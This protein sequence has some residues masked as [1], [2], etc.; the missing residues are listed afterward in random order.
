MSERIDPVVRSARSEMA[1]SADDQLSLLVGR[2]A[3]QDVLLEFGLRHLWLMLVT[4][5]NAA[6]LVPD[7]LTPLVIARAPLTASTRDPTGLESA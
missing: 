4:P 6:H 5:S 3:R 1:L 7:D 2:I